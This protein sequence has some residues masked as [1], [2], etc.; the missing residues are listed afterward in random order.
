[1]IFYCSQEIIENFKKLPDSQKFPRKFS[2]LSGT[3][4]FDKTF[5]R[6]LRSSKCRANCLPYVNQE[7]FQC[8]YFVSA[9]FWTVG[10]V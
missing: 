5:L 4:H 7:C 2:S 3:E 10:T 6:S 1:M 8:P 9:D